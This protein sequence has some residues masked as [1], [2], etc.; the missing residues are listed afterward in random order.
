[1]PVLTA[2]GISVL[3]VAAVVLMKNQ[4][5]KYWPFEVSA[6]DLNS[7]SVAR[8][9]RQRSFILSVTSAVNNSDSAGFVWF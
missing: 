5:V 9:V 8:N 2:V 7:H 6:T 1:L 4:T 3:T